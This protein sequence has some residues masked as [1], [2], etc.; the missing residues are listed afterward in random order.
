MTDI[1][2]TPPGLNATQKEDLNR[3][4]RLAKTMD[5]AYRLPIIGTRIG[6]DAILGLIPGVGDALALA[7]SFY[8]I[9]KAHGMGAPSGLLLRMGA[10]TAI[11]LAIGAIP[12]L[13][14]IFDIAWKSKLRNLALLEKHLGQRPG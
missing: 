6:W 8:I 5:S 7:P 10:N 13:G 4:R 12:L 3:L 14:D 2:D 1:E 11:D 9:A